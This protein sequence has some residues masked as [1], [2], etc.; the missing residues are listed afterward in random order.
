MPAQKFEHNPVVVE[1]L[2]YDGTPACGRE[3]VGWVFRSGHG[4]EAHYQEAEEAY[5]SPDG[6]KGRPATPAELCVKQLS[7]TTVVGKGDWVLRDLSDSYLMFEVV[8]E[9]EMQRLYAPQIKRDV[10][11]RIVV[12]WDTGIITIDGRQFP[13]PVSADVDI[14][15]KR[16]PGDVL[17][18]V[19]IPVLV[20]RFDCI[21]HPL[22]AESTPPGV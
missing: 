16:L 4:G 2:Q 3:I 6:M 7:G 15:S 19:S 9:A 14:A 12:D 17:T 13:Y 5:T 18:A 21:G 8:R 1:A 22:T 11:E 10:P 20:E